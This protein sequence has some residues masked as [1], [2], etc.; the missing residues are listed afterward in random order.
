MMGFAGRL[1]I[2]GLVLLLCTL[3]SQLQQDGVIVRSHLIDV[4]LFGQ[5][6]LLLAGGL[7]RL[8]DL[9]GRKSALPSSNRKNKR[10]Y[11]ST[12]SKTLP[13]SASSTTRGG[14]CPPEK[15]SSRQWASTNRRAST[16]QQEVQAATVN[17]ENRTTVTAQEGLEAVQA[18]GRGL[19]GAA[20]D[21]MALLW[22][23]VS[24]QPS[25]KALAP[26]FMARESGGGC[27]AANFDVMGGIS[28][29]E[30]IVTRIAFKLTSKF[31]KKVPSCE[32]VVMIMCRAGGDGGL[33]SG[34][35]A[36]AKLH[37]VPI[38]PSLQNSSSNPPAAHA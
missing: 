12:E 9:F 11:E 1:S 5:A 24:I 36:P 35:S 20:A 34:G 25:R 33:G 7:P 37:P 10:Y 29:G 4:I 2:S 26:I 31:Q 8:P 14:K 21:Y 19:L 32:L 15:S 6:L 30:T 27:S 38:S 28:N 18:E 16:S 22:L 13:R 23:P 3:V 17:P